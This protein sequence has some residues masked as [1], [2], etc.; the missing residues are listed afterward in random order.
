MTC[1]HKE[2]NVKI[3]MVRS[4]GGGTLPIR[5]VGRLCQH[6]QSL[7]NFEWARWSHPHH[8]MTSLFI[9]MWSR[10]GILHIDHITDPPVIWPM[11]RPS[12][13][14]IIL[15]HFLDS[16]SITN[17]HVNMWIWLSCS[18]ISCMYEDEWFWLSE[19]FCKC[20]T[21]IKIKICMTRVYKEYDIKVKVDYTCSL[22]DFDP[23]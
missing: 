11:W 9:S 23:L 19:P 13:L 8:N 4:A 18:C 6:L 1:V 7:I 15:Y 10:V 5:P 20:W 14:F 17:F 22:N 3:K 2:Y 12:W 16:S 21:S